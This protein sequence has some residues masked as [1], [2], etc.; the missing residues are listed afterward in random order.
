MDSPAPLL[1]KQW[2]KC[3]D[4]G[5]RSIVPAQVLCS[6]LFGY[7]AYLGKLPANKGAAL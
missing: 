1:A 6:A 2:K 5:V 4:L 3:F 7:L